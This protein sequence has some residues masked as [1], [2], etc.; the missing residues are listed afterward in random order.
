[1]QAPDDA[2]AMTPIRVREIDSSQ[3]PEVL[4]IIL[5]VF[6]EHISPLYLPEGDAEFE[7]YASLEAQLKRLRSGHSLLVAENE[8]DGILGVAE[9]RRFSHLSMFFVKTKHQRMGVGRR[10]LSGVIASCRNH[11]PSASELTVHASPNSVSAYRN[12]GFIPDGPEK[13]Q[14]GIRFTPMHLS[15]RTPRGT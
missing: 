15:L 11:L 6:R 12:L 1:M 5:A 10:L 2:P 13:V 3:V 14:D 9:L 4:G 7:R 8:Q